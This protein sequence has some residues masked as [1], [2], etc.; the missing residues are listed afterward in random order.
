MPP[1]AKPLQK[2]K[3]NTPYYYFALQIL[4]SRS[5]YAVHFAYCPWERESNIEKGINQQKVMFVNNSGSPRFTWVPF[6]HIFGI[7]KTR[8]CGNIPCPS[9]EYTGAVIKAQSC[10]W[11]CAWVIGPFFR[12]LNICTAFVQHTMHIDTDSCQLLGQ[13]CT[14]LVLEGWSACLFLLQPVT[15]IWVFWPLNKLH[16]FTPVL[17]Q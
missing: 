7:I 3:Y 11:C 2:W 6:P 16:W 10:Y 8:T 1:I 15:L 12:D 13:G 9:C 5:N 4:R 14:T 17:S